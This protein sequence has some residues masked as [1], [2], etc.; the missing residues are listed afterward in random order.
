[1]SAVRIAENYYPHFGHQD[2]PLQKAEK[3]VTF[4]NWVWGMTLI[5]SWVKTTE[6]TTNYN[7]LSGLTGTIASW[8]KVFGKVH[9]L[10][11]KSK[12]CVLVMG[13]KTIYLFP[14]NKLNKENPNRS[15]TELKETPYLSTYSTIQRTEKV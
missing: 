14:L 2:W 11:V 10:P 6:D 9:A 4:L 13:N 1:M 12:L 8:T 3:E 15:C 5:S 7:K